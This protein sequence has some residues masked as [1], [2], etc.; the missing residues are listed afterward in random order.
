MNSQDEKSVRYL[1][2]NTP[3]TD[4]TTP[5]H[6]IP[7]LVGATHSAGFKGYSCLDVNIEVLNYL[8]QREQVSELLDH[9]KKLQIDLEK[10]LRLTRG[11]QILYRYALKANGLKS[12]SVLA[13]I[14][15]MKDE[16]SFYN[17]NVYRQA[18]M[19]L[20]RWMDV[21]SV[22]GFPGQ[23]NGFY[24]NIQGVV[25]LSSIKD[26]TNEALLD[27]INHPFSKYFN[28]PFIKVINE[29]KWDI[30]GLSVNYM[31]QLPFAIWMCK[32][33]RKL[34]PKT[35]IFLGGT[36]VSDII[37]YL[38]DPNL[39]WKLFP[40]CNFIIVGEGESTLTEILTTIK[41]RQPL[42]MKSPGLLV[43]GEFISST[44]LPVRYEDI[45][46]SSEPK[47]DVWN[48]SN[49]WSPEPVILYSPTR[50]CYWN[51]CTFCD[52]GLNTDSPTSP[53][54]EKPVEVVIS[55][56]SN[57]SKFAKT[58]YFAVDAM[59]PIYLRKLANALV[60]SNISIKW[61]AELRLERSFK[62]DLATNLK[63]S[64][65]VCIS[66]GYESGSQRILNLIDKG[67]KLLDIPAILAQLSEA[68]IGA[69]M[70]GFI[71]FP[72]ETAEEALETFEFLQRNRQLW[73][74]AGIGDFI[75]TPG[76]IVAKRSQDFGI[77][78]IVPC[79]G[80]DITRWLHWI[81]ESN[82]Y[83]IPGD[84]RT[85]TINSM[86]RNLKLIPSDRPFVGG[87]DSGHSILYFAKFGRNLIPPTGDVC[88]TQSLVETVFYETPHSVVGKFASNE[89]IREYRKE[90]YSHG[91]SITFEEIELW[92][93]EYPRDQELNNT[94]NS[95]T[96]E[97][98]PSGDFTSTSSL[99]HSMTPA[100]E[101]LK[102]LLLMSKG[103]L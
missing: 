20:N 38:N 56:I 62:K 85:E 50:G 100:F 33:I 21:L 4:P 74:L 37:K 32:Q 10:K 47:Y 66:F 18:V 80:D 41:N 70:M 65:C 35:T 3:L 94:R 92:L 99:S 79:P 43:Q 24:L 60:E 103:I 2:I 97:I 53:S 30:V 96:L 81:D 45:F 28:G 23:F 76:A 84:M 19:L 67:V 12:D 40:S 101:E 49:Y 68:N 82:R 8:A 39:I 55:E 11:E 42:P 5:Y 22:Q 90:Q 86:N 88:S 77:K 1:L 87:I 72:S 69:Q 36:E 13:A 75:L 73:A 102:K 25:N 58:F 71:G 44:K 83:R 57:I 16:E 91:K 48:W 46:N 61:G 51:K 98:Y 31:L 64:G 17:Y 27:K 54:R 26:L 14:Q 6:S 63:L 59:S 89:T 52:Y 34:L 93:N 7:Y 95:T 9:C 78:E 29:S 15:V